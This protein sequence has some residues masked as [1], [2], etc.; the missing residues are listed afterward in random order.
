MPRYENIPPFRY[1]ECIVHKVILDANLERSRATLFMNKRLGY[2]DEYPEADILCVG[3]RKNISCGIVIECKNFTFPQKGEGFQYFGKIETRETLTSSLNRKR[4]A[5]I[6]NC[7]IE[8]VLVIAV[9][10]EETRSFEQ[11]DRGIYI[12][13]CSVIFSKGAFEFPQKAVELALAW[14]SISEGMKALPTDHS[15]LKVINELPI[16]RWYRCNRDYPLGVDNADFSQPEINSTEIAKNL[17]QSDY[18]GWPDQ[19]D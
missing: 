8:D 2:G 9:F 17:W 19:E 3:E 12:V 18:D 14:E 16:H 4:V 6:A 15:L 13:G 10:N 11:I 5:A 7:G 1:F